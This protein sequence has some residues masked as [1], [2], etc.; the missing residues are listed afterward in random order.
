MHYDLTRP[1]DA[2]PFLESMSHGFTDERLAQFA[3]GSFFCHKTCDTNDDGE[4]VATARSQHCAGALIWM[5]KR[6]D[7][8]QAA[9]VAGRLGLFNPAD[10]Q[11]V[12]LVR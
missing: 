9:R 4:F 11:D 12:D 2:C 6:G 1:C 5:D 3:S 7:Y 10:F 8:N